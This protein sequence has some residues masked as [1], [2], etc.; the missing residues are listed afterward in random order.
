MLSGGPHVQLPAPI[1][2]IG[3]TMNRLAWY[4][5]RVKA[6]REQITN[7]SLCGRGYE[8]FLPLYSH[9]PESTGKPKPLFPGYVIARFD[10]HNRLTVL[11]SPGVV[12]VVGF[13]SVLAPLADEEVAAIQ[14]MVNSRQPLYP[15]PYLREGQR[16]RIIKGS[17]T[18]VE[19]VVTQFRRGWRV[20]ASITI[21]QRSVAVEVD[22]SWIE[23]V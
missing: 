17:M 12:G 2:G 20:V 15:W 8:T 13:G 16:V 6:N 7:I 9:S 10:P 21:L 11:T 23:P 19:G 18:G 4:A 1:E 14:S 5:V 3:I 22:R